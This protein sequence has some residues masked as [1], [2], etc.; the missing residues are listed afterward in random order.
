[1]PERFTRFLF[2]FIFCLVGILVKG[3][4]IATF[5]KIYH[6]SGGNVYSSGLVSL[7]HGGFII[8][9]IAA[10]AIDPITQIESFSI[11]L[12]RTDS[13]GKVLWSKIYKS[14]TNN[15]NPFSTPGYPSAQYV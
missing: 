4:K 7:P 12:F 1:M 2:V 8:S 5:Q 6:N 14:D 15:G 10:T 13:L 3:Q 9:G 11:H